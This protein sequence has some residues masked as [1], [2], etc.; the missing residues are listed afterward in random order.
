[1]DQKAENPKPTPP[2]G[3]QRSWIGDWLDTLRAMNRRRIATRRLSRKP[4]MTPFGFLMNASASM[5][6]GNFEP[7][8][9]RLVSA[10]LRQADRF[11]NVG[12]NMGY[13]CCFAQAQNIDTVALEP[14]HSNVLILIQNMQ[15]NGWGEKIT[16]L[17]VAAGETPGFIDIYGVGTGSSAIRGWA[18]NPESLRQTVPVVRLHDVVA[19]PRPGETMLILMDVEGFEYF[20]LRGAADL[21]GAANKPVWLIEIVGFGDGTTQSR[22]AQATFDLMFAAGYVA[23]RAEGD[24]AVVAGPEPGVTN[25]LFHDAA[26]RLEDVLGRE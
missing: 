10:L 4:V 20:A 7:A 11:V 6:G 8:E 23:R 16:V 14:V 24:L 5:T 13:Y 21:I 17:P 25:Y 2:T 12:A 26:K 18:D 9:T 15:V 3:P 1:M 19:P 22:N